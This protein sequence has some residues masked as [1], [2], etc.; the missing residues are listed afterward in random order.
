[1]LLCVVQKHCLQVV[2]FRLLCCSWLNVRLLDGFFCV[3][4]CYIFACC[5][6]E[7]IMISCALCARCK[8]TVRVSFS[9]TFWD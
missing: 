7:Q 3:F 4:V 8:A 6:Q 2:R 9:L 5:Q 1:M